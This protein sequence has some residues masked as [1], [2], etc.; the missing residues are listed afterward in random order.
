MNNM[1]PF[2][3][4][5]PILI[6]Q[7]RNPVYYSISNEKALSKFRWAAANNK[8]KIHTLFQKQKM[9]KGKEDILYRQNYNLLGQVFSLHV[10]FFVQIHDIVYH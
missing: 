5:S 4:V 8:V 1:E 6:E 3:I 7:N 10:L 2:N 9:K